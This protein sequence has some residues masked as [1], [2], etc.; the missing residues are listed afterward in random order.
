M[1]QKVKDPVLSLQLPRSLLWHNFYPW[2]GNVHVLQVQPKKQKT[3]KPEWMLCFVVLISGPHP[4]HVEVP[5]PGIEPES[6]E[7]PEPRQ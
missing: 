1:V 3:K 2:L 4:W 5:G 7:R 6:Q